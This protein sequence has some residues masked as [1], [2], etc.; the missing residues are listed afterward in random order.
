MEKCVL[1]VDCI[2]L[3]YLNITKER[4]TTTDKNTE[5]TKKEQQNGFYRQIE[6]NKETMINKSSN[7]TDLNTD[8]ENN[9]IKRGVF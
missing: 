2:P 5:N 4:T 1:V 8:N 6:V 9:E 3:C 7:T